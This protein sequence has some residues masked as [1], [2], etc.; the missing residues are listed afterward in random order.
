M[1]AGVVM[2]RFV[3]WLLAL[4]A[5]VVLT[6][7]TYESADV[8]FWYVPD[9]LLHPGSRGGTAYYR[10]FTATEG[11]FVVPGSGWSETYRQA[12]MNLKPDPSGGPTLM[13]KLDPD[14]GPRAL[15]L[16]DLALANRGVSAVPGCSLADLAA[17]GGV[18]VCAVRAALASA[19]LGNN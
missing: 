11:P 4:V 13:F 14:R 17:R 10:I 18:C 8:N 6:C 9:S 7:W 2:A 12:P 3:Y 15:Q 19:R 16:I 5:C 1:T